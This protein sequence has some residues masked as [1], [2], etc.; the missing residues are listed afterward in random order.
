LELLSLLVPSKNGNKFDSMPK[1]FIPTSKKERKMI[2]KKSWVLAILFI[3]VLTACATMQSDVKKY[4][5]PGASA[6]SG[7]DISFKGTTKTPSGGI[8]TLTGKLT[9]PQGEGPFPAVVLLHSC[10]GVS[11]FMDSWADKLASLGY[12]ALVL[13]SFGPRGEPIGICANTMF[14]PPTVR[15]QDAFDAKVY[16]GGLP[17]V[18]RNQIAV[19][20]FSHGGITTL[21]AV[22]DSNYAAVAMIAKATPS[23]K[24]E[25]PFRAAIAFYPYCFDKLEDSNTPLLILSGVLDDWCPAALC[26]KNMPSGK[27]AQE[28][29]LKVYPGAYHGFDLEGL[30]ITVAGHRIRYNPEA[31]ADAI[32]QVKEF[33]AKHLK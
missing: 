13:D 5:P 12:V 14:I 20:G 18:D 19:M 33:L 32:K 25:D 24:L 30:D 1:F 15:S 28:I 7:K 3:F 31:T 9:K 10:A 6:F 22:S 29:T 4:I 11:K 27:T 16:L 26:Q 17:I 21:C 8:V 2:R 23:R